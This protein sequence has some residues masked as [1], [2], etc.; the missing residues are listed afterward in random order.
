MILDEGQPVKLVPVVKVP[1]RSIILDAGRTEPFPDE[2]FPA[3]QT[4]SFFPV[5]DDRARFR[6]ISFSHGLSSLHW[7]IV[8]EDNGLWI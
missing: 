3:P 8:T 6:C 5:D 7:S 1:G 2:L 4:F